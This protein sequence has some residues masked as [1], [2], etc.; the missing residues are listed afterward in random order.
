MTCNLLT[1]ISMDSFSYRRSLGAKVQGHTH[2]NRQ[3]TRLKA[4]LHEDESILARL[5]RGAVRSRDRHASRGGPVQRSRVPL[6]RPVLP[7][8]SR[9]LPG[10][11]ETLLSGLR[12]AR[13]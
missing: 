10:L 3:R 7:L 8:Q 4:Y 9:R 1:L 2:H 13:G 6:R 12:L 11:S 5:T